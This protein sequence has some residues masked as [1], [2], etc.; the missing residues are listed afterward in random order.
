M[1]AR[2]LPPTFR[3][4]SL[5]EV[6]SSASSSYQRLP[7]FLFKKLFYY[8]YC[9][10]IYFLAVLAGHM[11]SLFPNQG[12]NPQPLYWKHRVLTTEPSG[13]SPPVFLDAQSPPHTTLTSAST[14]TCSSLPSVLLLCS[15]KDPSDYPGTTWI[16]EGNFPVPPLAR[17]F[18]QDCCLSICPWCLAVSR[19]L[20]LAASDSQ[21]LDPFIPVLPF[22]LPSLAAIFFFLRFHSVIRRV[23]LSYV[24]SYT[25][26][27]KLGNFQQS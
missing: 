1:A 5:E 2:M 4:I 10:Y 12:Q 20:T 23:T 11:G 3:Y 7:V 16:I 17:S 21:C 19:C 14:S 22:F 24:A 6:L 18:T 27:K 13:K 25:E 8:S 15:Y 9:N 26:R